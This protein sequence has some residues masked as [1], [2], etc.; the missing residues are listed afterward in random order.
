MEVAV[1]GATG[2]AGVELVR[3]LLDHP[4]VSIRSVTS[5]SYAGQ[6]LGEVFPH[7]RGK[8]LRLA[9]TSDPVEVTCREADVVFLCLPH[10]LAMHVV[11]ELLERGKRVIDLGADFRLRDPAQY[12]TWYGQPHACPSLIAEA[13]YGLPE[14]YRDRIKAARLVANPGC[15][16]TSILLALAPL[17]G[18]P[19][20]DWS[21]VVAD[22]KSGVSGAGRGLSLGTHFCEVDGSVRPYQVGGQ[23]RHVP[24]IEQEIDHLL[25]GASVVKVAFTPHL[26]PMVRGM[27]A[28]VYVPI[29]R[30]GTGSQVQ[31]AWLR[32]LYL[33]RYE[34][35][36]FVQVLDEGQ[37]PSTQNVRG[38][39]LCQVGVTLEKRTGMVLAL[40]ALDNLGKGAAG[41]AVQ[42]LNIMMGWPE[43]TGLT[44]PP[45][46]P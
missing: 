29:G 18:L 15:Y 26:V 38:S 8:G 10:G 11:P 13:V 33:H 5:E 28:T 23:H 43:D 41:Q 39:N 45:L 19:G 46:V 7:L 24:E 3:L 22:C 36:P 44:R 14:L 25:R 4:R 35:E 17:A 2:Y 32:E 40:S 31:G 30:G 42:N 34:K 6:D 9:S 1:L 20:L 21:M 16:P 37:W 12:R 27:L